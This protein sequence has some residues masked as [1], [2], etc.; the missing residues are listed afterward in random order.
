MNWLNAVAKTL[1]P[2]VIGAAVAGAA[3]WIYAHTKGAVTVDA[4]AVAEQITGALV[5]YAASHRAASSFINPGDAAKQ[6]IADAEK[7]AAAAGTI[8]KVAPPSLF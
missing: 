3:G 1:G 4:A 7:N 2:R 8:V 5:V 6:R